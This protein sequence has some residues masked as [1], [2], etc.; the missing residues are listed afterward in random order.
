MPQHYII[1]LFTIV[2]NTAWAN[3]K[4][5]AF[6]D[7]NLDAMTDMSSFPW[8]YIKQNESN[9]GLITKWHMFVGLHEFRKFPVDTQVENIA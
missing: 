2:Y 3:R 7:I 1:L 8:Y 4:K 9:Q 5:L 6:I